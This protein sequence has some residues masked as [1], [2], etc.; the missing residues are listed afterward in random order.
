MW[1]HTIDLSQLAF[2]VPVVWCVLTFSNP[3]YLSLPSGRTGSSTSGAS[4]FSNAVGTGALGSFFRGGGA[5]EALGVCDY[6]ITCQFTESERDICAAGL[7]LFTPAQSKTTKE[8]P[9]YGARLEFSKER[10]C[11]LLLCRPDHQCAHA[12]CDGLCSLAPIWLLRISGRMPFGLCKSREAGYKKGW[13]MFELLSTA[14]ERY[15]AMCSG[16]CKV[17]ERER[18]GRKFDEAKTQ[19]LGKDWRIEQRVVLPGAAARQIGE[20]CVEDIKQTRLVD[21]RL[22]RANWRQVTRGGCHVRAL[23]NENEWRGERGSL[24]AAARGRSPVEGRALS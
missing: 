7:L 14:S 15:V 6:A 18:A 23:Q 20:G 16:Q 2:N 4:N 19:V 8:I 21:D 22:E 24:A 11:I 17:E 12:R 5:V 1:I 3:K 9:T 13:D 10:H